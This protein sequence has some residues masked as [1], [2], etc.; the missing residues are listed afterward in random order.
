MRTREQLPQNIDVNFKE[1]APAFPDGD[2]TI[3]VGSN[4]TERETWI[5]GVRFLLSSPPFHNTR[6][7]CI[8]WVKRFASGLGTDLEKR[9]RDPLYRMISVLEGS[10]ERGWYGTILFDLPKRYS[11][12]RLKAIWDDSEPPWLLADWRTCDGEIEACH[13]LGRLGLFEQPEGNTH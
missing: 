12:N 9:P 3:I 2:F 6:S 11:V 8:D 7:D 1:L 13:L 4:F 5:R 10:I